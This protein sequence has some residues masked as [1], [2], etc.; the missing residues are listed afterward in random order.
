MPAKAIRKILSHIGGSTNPAGK[1]KRVSTAADSSLPVDTVNL[2][3]KKGPKIS[4]ALRKTADDDHP[5]AQRSA[6]DDSGPMLPESRRRTRSSS[7][8]K[9]DEITHEP[10]LSIPVHRTKRSGQKEAGEPASKRLRQASQEIAAKASKSQEKG[11]PSKASRGKSRSK[12]AGRNAKSGPKPEPRE[13]CSDFHVESN[14]TMVRP[15]YDSAKYNAGIS[16]HDEE[17][18]NDPLEVAD[19]VT[20]I[21]QHF[22]QAEV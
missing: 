5:A 8:S 15:S 20:D 18:R 10:E 6:S 1:S 16:K 19:Y 11:V 7:R 13:L 12:S 3:A 21:Y 22:F 9:P 4:R 14:Y 17:N 2:D